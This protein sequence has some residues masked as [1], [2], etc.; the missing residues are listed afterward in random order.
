M[1]S[2]QDYTK[3]KYLVYNFWLNPTNKLRATHYQKEEKPGIT[4]RKT[5]DAVYQKNRYAFQGL[6]TEGGFPS[7]K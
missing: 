2:F 7:Q 4:D 1:N 3:K 6:S 5:I